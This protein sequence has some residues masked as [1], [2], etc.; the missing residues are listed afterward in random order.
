MALLLNDFLWVPKSAPH[1]YIWWS[2][3]IYSMWRVDSSFYCLSR[4]PCFPSQVWRWLHGDCPG[5]RISPSAEASR[6]FCPEDVPWQH[7]EGE[8]S[9]HT[10][11]SVPL[12]V[13]SLGQHFQTVFQP[14]AEAG[15]RRLL[16][17]PDHPGS[18]EARNL[19]KWH[20]SI[21][22]FYALSIKPKVPMGQSRKGFDIT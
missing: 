18:G 3:T 1:R 16:C 15:N 21:L 4:N 8:A 17:V 2:H 7:S 5:R 20:S 11:I 12:C 19:G 10:A 14:A 13:G 6:G 22:F 9:Q